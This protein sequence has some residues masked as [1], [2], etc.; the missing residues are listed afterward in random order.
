MSAR[1][2]QFYPFFDAIIECLARVVDGQYKMNAKKIR[3]LSHEM[4][5]RHNVAFSA[6]LGKNGP[7]WGF[8][9]LKKLQKYPKKSKKS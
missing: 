7:V 2:P 3:F 9:D 4:S 1:V 8:F 6:I 5:R